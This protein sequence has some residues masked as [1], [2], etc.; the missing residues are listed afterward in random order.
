MNMPDQELDVTVVGASTTPMADPL[1][2]PVVAR[3]SGPDP[4]TGPLRVGQAF[5]ARYHI[6][7]TLGVGGMGAVFRLAAQ[8]ETARPWSNEGRPLLCAAR[9]GGSV[10]QFA[11]LRPQ[12]Q[13]R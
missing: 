11:P 6:I 3:G 13:A 9:V 4:G 10:R 7:R 5:S 12:A 2:I 1:A 8:L